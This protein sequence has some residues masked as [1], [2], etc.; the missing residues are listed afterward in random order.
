MIEFSKYPWITTRF[1]LPEGEKEEQEFLDI[2]KLIEKKEK[3]DAIRNL[4]V[5]Y[6]LDQ[7]QKARAE[8]RAFKLEGNIGKELRS[9]NRSQS[10]KKF[11]EDY[12]KE[13][14]AKFQLSGIV[15]VV[16]G[17]LILFFLRAILAQKFLI[18]FSVDALV[19]AV[20]LVFFYRNMKMKLKLLKSYASAKDYI[21]L[22]VASFVLC[23]LLKMWMPPT[24]DISLI[25]LMISYYI[26]RR[27]FDKYLKTL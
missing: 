22:D 4:Y 3:Q 15:I 14:R 16:T 25:V 26:Q 13:E 20:A 5:N 24:F 6:Y 27:I 11:K 7:Y 2:V 1:P 10:F 18:N 8:D 21:Y 23:L 19:G 17:T 9:W 12:L